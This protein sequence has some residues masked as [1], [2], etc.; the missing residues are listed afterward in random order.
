MEIQAVQ[1]HGIYL[2]ILYNYFDIFRGIRL[3]QTSKH[4]VVYWHK[5]DIQSSVGIL[6]RRAHLR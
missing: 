3:F 5:H 4:V 1:L 6:V 2:R